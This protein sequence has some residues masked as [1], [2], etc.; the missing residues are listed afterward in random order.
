VLSRS[1]AVSLTCC[2]LLSRSCAR[3]CAVSCGLA[4][5]RTHVVSHVC[6]L[7]WSRSCAVSCGLARVLS[8]SRA[9]S[10]ARHLA[11][12]PFR[13]CAISHAVSCGSLVC[14]LAR[15]LAGIS[16]V[17]HLAC[18]LLRSRAISLT[19]ILLSSSSCLARLPFWLSCTPSPASLFNGLARLLYWLPHTLSLLSSSDYLARLPFK[20]SRTPSSAIS[21]A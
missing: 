2:L 21:L 19:T 9:V 3:P 1:C 17:C 5:V 20:L 8:L 6:D 10:L 16:L 18:V 4:R 15:Y 14:S 11:C 12:V 7:L 13:W